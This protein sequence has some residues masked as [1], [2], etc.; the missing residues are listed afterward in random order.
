MYRRSLIAGATIATLTGGT[1]MSDD[2]A[3]QTKAD[4]ENTLFMDL[5]QGR[6]VIQ[7]FPDLA[8]KHVERVKQLARLRFRE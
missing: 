4:P 6:V 1:I 7:L 3:A 8:P 5:K 2:A